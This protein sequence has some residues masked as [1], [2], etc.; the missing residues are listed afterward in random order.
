M[1]GVMIFKRHDYLNFKQNFHHEIIIWTKFPPC[2]WL[3]LIKKNYRLLYRSRNRSQRPACMSTQQEQIIN[4]KIW[5]WLRGRY[6]DDI[7]SSWSFRLADLLWDMKVTF[8][9]HFRVLQIFFFFQRFRCKSVLTKQPTKPSCLW[10][11][12]SLT[13]SRKAEF[14]LA[15]AG[16]KME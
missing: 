1:E 8:H 13:P 4:P 6:G 16:W 7:A 10:S 14:N 2:L 12:M 15:A 5:K 3:L 11:P 9:L